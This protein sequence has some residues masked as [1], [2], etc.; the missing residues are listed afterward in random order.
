MAGCATDGCVALVRD[1]EAT[2][3]CVALV[4]DAK[5]RGVAARKIGFD[6]LPRGAGWRGATEVRGICFDGKGETSGV[7]NQRS[8]GKRGVSFCKGCFPT[9]FFSRILLLKG[10][11][12]IEGREEA[13]GTASTWA[14]PPQINTP[15]R[16]PNHLKP[17]L[18]FMGNS[19][20]Q[21]LLALRCAAYK[22][23]QT[24]KAPC[25][26]AQSNARSAKARCLS[27]RRAGYW[28]GG[29]QQSACLL[30]RFVQ[31]GLLLGLCETPCVFELPS[32]QKAAR[33]LGLPSQQKAARASRYSQKASKANIPRYSQPKRQAKLTHRPTR[34]RP[35]DLFQR[36][37]T[38]G[39]TCISGSPL[40]YPRLLLGLDQMDLM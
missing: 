9:G 37:P 6:T 33:A 4:G 38:L 25:L 3:G 16:K 8:S 40:G 2:G 11:F 22:T 21:R 7:G 28:G 36:A 10:F 19:F 20:R 29:R 23:S 39:R 12:S 15:K 31:R 18:F 34:S 17:N 27:R 30:Y 1:A 5:R 24:E 14:T 32:Q 35:R 26:S 13:G